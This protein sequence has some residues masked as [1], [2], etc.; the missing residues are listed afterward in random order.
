MVNRQ[1]LD[2]RKIISTITTLTID[3]MTNDLSIN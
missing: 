2:I 1:Y 3:P